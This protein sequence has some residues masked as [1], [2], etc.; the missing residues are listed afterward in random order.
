MQVPPLLVPE[1]A[2]HD[3][4]RS[5]PALPPY[6]GQ[7]ELPDCAKRHPGGDVAAVAGGERRKAEEA[8]A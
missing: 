1:G 6:M 8:E 4:A 5:A 2:S 3:A 7:V